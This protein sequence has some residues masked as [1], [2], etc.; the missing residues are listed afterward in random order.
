MDIL[1]KAKSY[2]EE[3]AIKGINA[4]VE[5][6]YIDGYNDG[7]KHHENEMLD[8]IKDGVEYVDLGLPSGTLWSSKFVMSDNDL[9]RKMA[10]LEASKINIPTLEQYEELL[11]NC[12]FRYKYQRIDSYVRIIGVTGNSIIIKL[13]I[14][15]NLNESP[16]IHFWLK[17]E[18]D[19]NRK[20]AACIEFHNNSDPVL[21]TKDLFMGLKLPVMLVMNK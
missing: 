17:N 13:V 2:A 19:S 9:M 5:Q 12:E 16:N 21:S 18:V 10:Y 11:S 3:K 14:I 7:M 20:L 6:A 4:L 8:R 1:E 15:D